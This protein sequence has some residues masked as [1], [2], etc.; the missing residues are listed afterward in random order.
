MQ[1]VGKSMERNRR[2][3]NVQITHK[4]TTFVTKFYIANILTPACISEMHNQKVA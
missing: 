2:D 3:E 1:N 4:G